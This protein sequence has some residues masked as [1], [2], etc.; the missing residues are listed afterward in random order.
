MRT[1]LIFIG[2][3]FAKYEV[4]RASEILHHVS[5]VIASVK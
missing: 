1:I 2:V 4:D 3:M 5:D